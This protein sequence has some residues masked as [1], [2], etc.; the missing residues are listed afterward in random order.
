MRGEGERQPKKAFASHV[1][2]PHNSCPAT[3]RPTRGTSYPPLLPTDPHAPLLESCVSREFHAEADA[4]R[5]PPAR[6][7]SVI[8]KGR[9]RRVVIFPTNAPPVRAP[10]APRAGIARSPSRSNRSRRSSSLT[11]LLPLLPLD[12]RVAAKAPCPVP[13]MRTACWA[14]PRASP[15]SPSTSATSTAYAS[16]I[17]R[18]CPV[19]ISPA[20]I[21]T[22]SRVFPLARRA[23][24]RCRPPPR[25]PTFAI[26][27]NRHRL[28]GT[29]S[30]SS[31]DRPLTDP[32]LPAQLLRRCADPPRVRR[33]RY[34]A[35]LR[36]L[37][38]H[39]HHHPGT[40]TLSEVPADFADSYSYA[41][42]F[43]KTL[44]R[45]SPKN[46]H[47]RFSGSI[48]ERFLA[49]PFRDVD[50]S[51]RGTQ[52]VF[53]PSDDFFVLAEKIVRWKK[54][55]PPLMNLPSR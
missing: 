47:S 13:V 11:S 51:T 35:R 18:T 17:P 53:R 33:L 45:L 48:G 23:R 14:S 6:V 4:R 52:T 12:P 15:A 19:P 2:P 38:L 28:C 31:P 20:A 3:S 30:P 5:R 10:R 44:S 1:I 43:P 25:R 27:G 22:R 42:G 29:S 21:S 49:K 46:P 24:D 16:R 39:L 7:S 26:L 36:H 54:N 32:P 8:A 41:S 55:A 37:L 34:R 9:D 40:S 50:A